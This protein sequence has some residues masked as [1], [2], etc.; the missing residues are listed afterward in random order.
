M[1]VPAVHRV[2]MDHAR[3][4]LKAEFVPS[5]DARAFE[6]HGEEAGA[7]AASAPQAWKRRKRDRGMNKPKDRGDM[8]RAPRSELCLDVVAGRVC[9]YEDRCLKSHDLRAYVARREPDLAFECPRYKRNGFCPYGVLCRMGARHIDGDGNN[10]WA[11]GSETKA[12]AELNFLSKDMCSALRKRKVPFSRAENALQDLRCP[13]R[14]AVKDGDKD[15]DDLAHVPGTGA[16]AEEGC[17]AEARD[18]VAAH[19]HTASDAPFSD[20]ATARS[21]AERATGAGYGCTEARLANEER[22]A[23]D[24]RG[25]LYLAPLTTVGNL[26]FRRLC[27]KLGAD[28]TCS[29]MAH[30]SKLLQGEGLEWALMRRHESEKIFGVQIAGAHP[31]IVAK[32]CDVIHRNCAVDFVDLNCG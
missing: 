19:V 25:K 18:P 15:V 13:A 22:R 4:S 20:G 2:A 1:F 8:Y 23:I 6:A 28:I 29:E 30:G 32:A 12:T 24:L 11:E 9:S 16:T 10:L 5:K 14:N 7:P 31:D 3:L 26:P 17:K 27:V 21:Q